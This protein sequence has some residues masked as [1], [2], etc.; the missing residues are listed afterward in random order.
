MSV[1]GASVV[2]I[3]KIHGLIVTIVIGCGVSVTYVALILFRAP[4]CAGFDSR[5]P[6]F[7]FVVFCPKFRYEILLSLW[8]C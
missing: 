7:I 1:K 3:F 6:K 8:T 4:T 2:Y 5:H